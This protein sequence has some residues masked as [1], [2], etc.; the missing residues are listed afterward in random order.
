ML[1]FY[2]F[3]MILKNQV[4]ESKAFSK[5]SDKEL[6]ELA[7]D[8]VYI[9]TDIVVVKSVNQNAVKFEM[10]FPY[11]SKKTLTDTRFFLESKSK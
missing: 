7:N 6:L 4:A 2:Y 10:V 5:L 9:H 11:S 1:L 8:G 3:D